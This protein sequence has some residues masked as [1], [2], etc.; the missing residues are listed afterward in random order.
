MVLTAVKV[1]VAMSFSQGRIV[2]PPP[3]NIFQLI[4]I[5]ARRVQSKDHQSTGF[6][7]DGFFANHVVFYL[8]LLVAV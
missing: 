8:T 1:L 3:S 4:V 2:I 7:F 5:L 6:A